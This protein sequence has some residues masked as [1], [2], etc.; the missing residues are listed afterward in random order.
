MSFWRTSATALLLFSVGFMALEHSAG[1]ASTLLLYLPFFWC[2]A[3]ASTQ[4]L[5]DRNRSAAWLLLLLI[6]I[7]GPLWLAIQLGL[8]RG[9]RGDNRYG[10]EP[11]AQA[12]P[13]Q[14]VA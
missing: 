1:R 13:Y 9:T 8:L 14:T 3:S 4:R 10:A 2:V 5:H 7:V 6:P 12:L 11:R